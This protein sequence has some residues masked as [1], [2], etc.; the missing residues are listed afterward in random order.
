[1]PIRCLI[2]DDSPVF[3]ESARRLLESEGLGVVGTASTSAEAIA[4]AAELEPDVVLVD[5]ELGDENGFELARR[6]TASPSSPPVILIST[7]P[8]EDVADLVVS[9]SAAGF[10]AKSGLSAEAVQAMLARR[11]PGR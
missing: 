5:V 7:H 1:M 8:E 4:L 6:L 2:V 11:S 9:S 3:L 10:I